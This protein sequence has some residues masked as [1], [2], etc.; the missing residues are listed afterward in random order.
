MTCIR[1]EAYDWA[2]QPAPTT[3]QPPRS[4]LRPMMP[5]TSL[6]AS[7]TLCNAACA[8]VEAC[9]R[10]RAGNGCRAYFPAERGRA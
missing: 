5:G 2:K 8:D 1:W 6:I 9:H 7:G 4:R 3:E 10:M